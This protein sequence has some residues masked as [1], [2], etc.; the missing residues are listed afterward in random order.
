M[1][2]RRQFIGGG[3]T[4]IALSA[5]ALGA[6]RTLAQDAT[7]TTESDDTQPSGPPIIG[8]PTLNPTIDLL[9]AQQIA[10]EGNPGTVVTKVELDGEDG[11]LEYAIQLDNGIEVD[12]DAMT[13][14][15]TKT[16]PSDDGSDGGDGNQD[17]NEG[18]SGNDGGDQDS[19]DG[20]ENGNDQEDGD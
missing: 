5:L 2:T 11:V 6:S 18:D 9:K 20:G 8:T 17:D 12:I 15:I 10:L 19:N 3:A 16:E 14:T 4:T 13:G 1:S 7:P